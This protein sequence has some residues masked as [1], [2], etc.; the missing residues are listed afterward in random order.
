MSTSG[1]PFL[2]IPGPTNVP[3]RVLR[4]MDRP[5]I[6][7]RGPEFADLTREILPPLREVFGTREGAIVLYPSSG[8]GAWEAS[9]VNV[10]SPGERVL[11]F[12]NGHFSTVFAQTARN[13]GYE[14]DEVPLRW[15][16]EVPAEEVEARL[17]DDRGEGRY[18]AVLVVHNETS[19]GVTSDIGALRAAMDRAGH[20]ALLIV[21]TVSSLASIEFKFD[22]WRV[23]VALTG[24]Q[25]GLMLP[26]GLALVCAGPRALERG[27]TGGSPRNFF[28]WRP[29]IQENQAGV[30]PYTPA[31]LLLFGLREALTMLVE[32]EGLDAVYA[33]HRSLA[34][35]VRAAVSA[36][37]LPN[38]CERPEF[39]S[40]T[41][42]AVVV[43][44]NIDSGDIVSTARDRFGLALGIGLTQIKGKVFRIGHLGA[45]NELEVLGTLGGVEMALVESGVP[46]ELG[47]GGSAAQRL[48]T[49][50]PVAAS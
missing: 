28:D 45:L 48:F 3:D 50:A 2:Q 16:Q 9:L 47:S 25:K 1:R 4:A 41:L 35:G 32:E 23:D 14:V 44:E 15:G 17:K 43:P 12:S 38:L 8:T 22:E 13:L 36:W 49:R 24:S 21:D 34:E 30:F 29:I 18:A 27:E 10:L 40:N 31:T 7:H 42:T 19:T 26:P 37:E 39:Y 5:V 20:D 33:R 11:S 46:V 6:D